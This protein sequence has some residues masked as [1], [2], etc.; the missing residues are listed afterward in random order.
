MTKILAL[1]AILAVS[2]TGCASNFKPVPCPTLPKMESI[3]VHPPGYFQ[4]QWMIYLKDFKAELE[5]LSKKP[6][7]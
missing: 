4:T 1:S 6:T 7:P 2:L 3:Q 5:N